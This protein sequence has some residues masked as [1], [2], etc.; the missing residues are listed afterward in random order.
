MSI[1]I[2]NI[3]RYKQVLITNLRFHFI[4]TFGDNKVH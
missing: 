4:H 3:L 1:I 2:C